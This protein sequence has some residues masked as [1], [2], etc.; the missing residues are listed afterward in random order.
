MR[1]LTL[2][3]LLV[4]LGLAPTANSVELRTFNSAEDEARFRDLVAELRCLVC[5]NQSLSDSDAELARDL[6]RE[7][8]EMIEAGQT[9]EQITDFMV[10]R[11][12]D[13]VLYRPPFKGATAALW[14]AP[15]AAVPIALGLLVLAIRS[16]RRRA[17]TD[18]GVADR[19]VA[20]AAAAAI[21]EKRRSSGS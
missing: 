4:A 9:N 21:V 12:G 20:R 2:L 5:Q 1:F 7:V 10:A 16:R 17:E 15:F 3:A 6:R 11:Y 13:F 19:E 8:H 18:P 14:I